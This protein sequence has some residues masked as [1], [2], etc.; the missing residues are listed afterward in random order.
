MLL[1]AFN[2]TESS[3]NSDIKEVAQRYC[4]VIKA[5]QDMMF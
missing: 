1:T 2:G 4:K 3:I 5:L